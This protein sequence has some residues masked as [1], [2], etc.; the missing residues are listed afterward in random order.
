M[1][2]MGKYIRGYVRIRLESPAP[3]RFFSLCVHNRIPLRNLTQEGSCYEMELSARDFLRLGRFRRKTNAR[4]HILR[5]NGLPFFLHRAQKRKAFFLGILLGM[6]LL[7]I[8]SFRIW[9]IQI[10]GNRYY[11]TPVLLETLSEWEISCGMAKRNV[12]CQKLMQKIR[13]TFPGIV[14]VSARLEGT[15]LIIDIQCTD[16]QPFEIRLS[17]ISS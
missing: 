13:Q 1:D 17:G 4:I 7:A 15:C 2:S 11:T 6:V 10:A 3:E 12:D 5:K 9:D 16:I 8:C 14:W